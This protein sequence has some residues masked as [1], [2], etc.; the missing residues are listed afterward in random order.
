MI[1]F[2]LSMGTLSLGSVSKLVRI[3][4]ASNLVS[5]PQYF[6]QEIVVFGFRVATVELLRE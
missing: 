3:E 4:A 5:L 1:I 2:V 6:N